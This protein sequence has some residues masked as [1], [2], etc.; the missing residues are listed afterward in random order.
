VLFQ[1][2]FPDEFPAVGEVLFV[3]I[4]STIRIPLSRMREWLLLHH[5]P[6]PIPTSRIRD[7]WGKYSRQLL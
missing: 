7:P 5:D 2:V 4:D 6:F 1:T 3:Q